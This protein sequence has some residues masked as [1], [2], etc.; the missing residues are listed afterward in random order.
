LRGKKVPESGTRFAEDLSLDEQ[1][2]RLLGNLDAFLGK[3]A[4]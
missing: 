2:A 4:V 3:L 1:I